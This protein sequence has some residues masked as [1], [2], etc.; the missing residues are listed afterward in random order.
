MTLKWLKCLKTGAKHMY[1]KGF[2]QPS[3]LQLTN[4]KPQHNVDSVLLRTFDR[5]NFKAR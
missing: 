4:L 1:A 3:D 5:S 2:C